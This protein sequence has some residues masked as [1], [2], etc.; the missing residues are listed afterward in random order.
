MQSKGHVYLTQGSE[1]WT[2]KTF[3]IK[4][5]AGANIAGDNDRLPPFS[6]D[7]LPFCVY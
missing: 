1:E 6:F 4:S 5:G 7:I 2:G 3:L